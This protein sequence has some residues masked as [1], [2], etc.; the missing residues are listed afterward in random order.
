[1]Y[2]GLFGEIE[3]RFPEA[4]KCITF[5]RNVPRY[6]TPELVSLFRPSHDW[7]I[8]TFTEEVVLSKASPSNFNLFVR[9][10]AGLGDMISTHGA[11]MGIKRAYPHFEIIYQVSTVYTPMFA[12]HH[13]YKAVL[14]MNVI[15]DHE[16]I[17]AFVN[18]DTVLEWDHRID[19]PKISRVDRAWL[20]IFEGRPEMIKGLKPDFSLIIPEETRRWAFAALC[21]LGIDR[22]SR[23]G[24]P[25]IT[26]APRSTAKPRQMYLSTIKETARTL[27]KELSAEVV[28]IEY[29]PEWIW[30]EP[31][32]HGFERSDAL[33]A[34]ALIMESDVLCTPDAGAM[35]LGHAAAV[36]TVVWFG[37]TP[38]ETKINH[39]P[40]Y[41]HGT[42]G[43]KM[44]KWV[45]CPEVCYE[46]ARWCN[47]TMK[48]LLECDS[49]K[50]ARETVR[51]VGELLE[52]D[53]N[54]R[55]EGQ[56]GSADQ[57]D[58]SGDGRVEGG[59]SGESRN[60]ANAGAGDQAPIGAA[61]ELRSA[62]DES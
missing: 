37:P 57:P 6:L 42:R 25:L 20:Q 54:G 15:V 11:L 29:D 28:L 22:E 5:K 17:D 7:V 32:I 33:Q 4:G 62:T 16:N 13:G 61:Q 24:R 31:H 51:V 53:K 45:G 49:G 27:A 18:L 36:P 59:A 26:L 1:M 38:P 55:K 43:L 46:A 23:K 47:Y 41:P 52:W 12:G 58:R 60:G 50:L 9:R 30:K 3:A 14:P 19:S 35:W 10:V 21:K 44:W 39:H 34:L 56:A 48:C 40:L 2:T 8:G